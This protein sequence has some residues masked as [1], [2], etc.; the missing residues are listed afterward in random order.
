MNPAAQAAAVDRSQ[1]VRVAL[2]RLVAEGGFHGASMSAVA[3]EAGVA[4]GTAYVHYASKDDLV[5]AAYVE[6]KRELGLAATS[7]LEADAPPP[8]RFVALWLAL[9]KHL[10]ANPQDARFLIQVEHSP[11]Q[12]PAHEAALAAS[13]DPLVAFAQAPDLTTLLAPLPQE[14]LWELGLA[15]AIR[16]GCRRGQAETPR[17][18]D[19][20]RGLLEGD[21]DSGFMGRRPVRTL[22]LGGG[23][24]APLVLKRTRRAPLHLRDDLVGGGSVGGDPGS[25]FRVEHRRKARDAVSRVDADFRIEADVNLGALV[26]LSHRSKASIAIRAPGRRTHGACGCMS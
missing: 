2:R 10:A 4:T 3:K 9:H 21:H 19:R 13:D 24:G 5:I 16:L 12:G 14:V 20:S 17:A 26:G 1:A 22:N 8:E 25:T 6:T 7:K 18:R 11:Y 23:L 15:P